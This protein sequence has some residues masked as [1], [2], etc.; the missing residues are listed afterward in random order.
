MEI[1][2]RFTDAP[3]VV[4]GVAE[5]LRTRTYTVLDI[6]GHNA[7]RV[8]GVYAHFDTVPPTSLIRTDL[9]QWSKGDYRR[10]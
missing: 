5:R 7:S 2:Y 9:D 6:G 4:G 3:T 1:N 8:V 10:L